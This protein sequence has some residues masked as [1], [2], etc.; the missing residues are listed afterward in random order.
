MLEDIIAI[1]KEYP[2]NKVNDLHASEIEIKYSPNMSDNMQV[3]AQAYVNYTGGNAPIPPEIAL[4]LINAT[5]D[6]ITIGKAIKEWGEQLEEKRQAQENAKMT[7]N[8]VSNNG[9]GEIQK[10]LQGK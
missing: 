8:P 9:T 5:S 4:A 10:D 1:C 2:D 3:K 7:Q 6:P